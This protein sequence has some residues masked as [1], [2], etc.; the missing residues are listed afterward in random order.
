VHRVR[1]SPAPRGRPAPALAELPTE[2]VN[3]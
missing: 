3:G 2:V 1:G